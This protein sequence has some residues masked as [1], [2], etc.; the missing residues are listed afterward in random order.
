MICN[1]LPNRNWFQLVSTIKPQTKANMNIHTRSQQICQHLSTWKKALAAPEA[2]PEPEAVGVFFP[3]LCRWKLIETPCH[4]REVF[5]HPIF[6]CSFFS[7]CLLGHPVFVLLLIV[8][9]NK[10]WWGLRRRTERF[11]CRGQED[12]PTGWAR[13]PGFGVKCWIWMELVSR[14]FQEVITHILQYEESFLE[15]MIVAPVSWL[16]LGPT[17]HLAPWRL[18]VR[19]FIQRSRR[20]QWLISLPA[21]F[22]GARQRPEIF[23]GPM[24]HWNSFSCDQIVPNR[25]FATSEMQFTSI[26]TVCICLRGEEDWDEEDRGSKSDWT[27]GRMAFLHFDLIGGWVLGAPKSVFDDVAP[28]TAP[29]PGISSTCSEGL[30]LQ[31]LSEIN[32]WRHN[33]N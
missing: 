15:R 29:G 19:V 31:P 24:D 2:P 17:S 33:S 6:A 18:R 13:P 8:W 11:V 7:G 23:A 9:P 20:G 21:R 1:P 30:E 5:K 27:R 14:W 32:P 3:V 12:R 25:S 22:R 16:R 28:E 4:S 10:P 26:H